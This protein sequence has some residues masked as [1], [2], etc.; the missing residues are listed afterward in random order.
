MKL[1]DDRWLRKY[2]GVAVPLI[3]VLLGTVNVHVPSEKSD[4][5][6]FVEPASIKTTSP[7]VGDD[8]GLLDGI[9]N[10][11]CEGICNQLGKPDGAN[12]GAGPRLGVISMSDIMAFSTEAEIVISMIQSTLAGTALNVSMCAARQPATSKTSKLERTTSPL[13]LIPMTRLP[14]LH[15]F[16]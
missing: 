15:A 4:V 10:G 16:Q 1:G 13:I 14:T 11:C 9:K 3:S 2:C 5:S 6:S 7:R 8:D 12:V